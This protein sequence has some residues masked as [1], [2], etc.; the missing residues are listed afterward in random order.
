MLDQEHRS[1]KQKSQSFPD[2]SHAWKQDPSLDTPFRPRTES[3][4]ASLAQA[5]SDDQRASL[6]RRLHQSYG[7][8]YVQR[9][10]T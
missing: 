9:L 4:S 2:S 7:N 5:Q 6:I 8:A 3:H 1:G 10:L